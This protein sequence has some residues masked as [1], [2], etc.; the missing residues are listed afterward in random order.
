MRNNSPPCERGDTAEGGG[1]D[2]GPLGTAAPTMF[3]L[4]Q[5]LKALRRSPHPPQCAHWGTF[6]Q[7]KANS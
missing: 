6:P 1:G 3:V 2:S 4:A 7:G 5:R